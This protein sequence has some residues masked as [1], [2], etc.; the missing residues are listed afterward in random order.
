MATEAAAGDQVLVEVP[1]PEPTLTATV[2][3]EIVGSFMIATLGLGIGVANFVFSHQKG[4]AW[5]GDIWPTS[6]GWTLAIALAI[7]CTASLSGAHFNPAVTLAL[8]STGRHPWKQVPHYIVCQPIGWFLGAALVVALFGSNIHSVANSMHIKYGDPGSSAVGSVLTT[9]VPN[10]GVFGT[11]STAFGHVPIGIGFLAEVLGTAILLYVIL[12]LLETRHANAPAAWFFP[13]II[14]G[15]IGLLIMFVAGLTQASFNSARDLGPRFMLLLMGFGKEAFPGPRDGLALMVT[16]VGPLVG[17]LAGAFFHD[18]VV[19]PHI[20]GVEA[21]PEITS[22][23]EMAREPQREVATSLLGHAPTMP[24]ELLTGDEGGA[25]GIDLVMLDV[26]GTIYDDDN[27]AQALLRATR[28]QAGSR[29]DEQEFWR[30]YD[31]A[32][33]EQ[34][35]LREALAE[36][37]LGGDAKRLSDRA[38]AIVEYR[39]DSIYPDVRPTLE[40][41]GKR[42]KLGVASQNDP[43]IDALRRDGLIGYFSVIATPTTS[44]HNKTDPRFWEWALAQAGVPADRAVHVGNRLDS[45]IMPTRQVGMRAIWLLRGESPPSPTVEQLSHADAVVTSFSGVPHALADMARRRAA[46]S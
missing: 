20:P 45:D 46:V 43:I 9:Y 29:F 38:E 35:A 22:P 8:A 40:V 28:E 37:F 19:R 18:K 6:F 13:L 5:F 11:G 25:E 3:G 1:A 34:S 26:G 41:L 42:Y 44:G 17:G 16:T 23:G 15:T 2:I 27:F 4:G 10:P 30:I 14:G 32:R 7:Y 39:S 31:H 24:P 33:Q 36:N 21:E 12:S